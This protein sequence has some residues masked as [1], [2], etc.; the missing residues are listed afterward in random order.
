MTI[1]VA[2][3]DIVAPIEE[4]VAALVEAIEAAENHLLSLGFDPARLARRNRL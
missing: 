2:E 1:K 3:A 4:L